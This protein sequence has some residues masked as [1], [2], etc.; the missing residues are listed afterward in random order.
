MIDVKATLAALRN[1][2]KHLRLRGVVLLTIDDDGK[3]A[4]V[5]WGRSG[6]DCRDIS[7]TCDYIADL[8]ELGKVWLPYW[9]TAATETDLAG[10][11]PHEAVQASATRSAGAP[12]R[13]DTPSNGDPSPKG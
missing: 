7:K 8:I 2:G 6:D 13:P 10:G 1:L 5:S 9:R 4:V 12:G 3:Y 11:D